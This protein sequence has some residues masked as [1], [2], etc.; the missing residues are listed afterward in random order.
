V[1]H[2]RLRHDAGLYFQPIGDDIF[3]LQHLGA[4]RVK[5]QELNADFLSW[6]P[7]P[8][9]AKAKGYKCRPGLEQ[10]VPDFLC[11]T[12]TNSLEVLQ[13]FLG[14]NQLLHLLLGQ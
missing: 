10:K 3:Q 8:E 1:L 4:S 7:G 6:D 13:P 12:H 11:L 9:G 5:Q 2:N 14:C